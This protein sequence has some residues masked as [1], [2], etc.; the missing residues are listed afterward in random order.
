MDWTIQVTRIQ[1][2]IVSVQDFSGKYKADFN[3]SQVKHYI[4][5][6]QQEDDDE[7]VVEIFHNALNQF[8]SEAGQKKPKPYQVLLTEVL[9]PGDPREALFDE[10]KKKEIQ[11]LVEKGTWKVILKSEMSPN[12]NILGGRFVLAIKDAGTDKEKWKARFVVQGHRD[13][14]KTSLVHDSPTARQHSTRII[15]GLAAI[16]GFRLFST[17]VTQA[18][19]QSSTDLL[20]DVYMKP[21]KEFHLNENQIL[22]LLKPLYGLPDSGDYWGKTFTT[23]LRDELGMELATGDGAL[24]FKHLDDKLKGLCATY[25]D[26]T[27]QAG[28][29]DFQKLTEN[30]LRKFECG[31][32][33]WDNTEF[34]GVQIET[35]PEEFQIYQT[36]YIEN[37]KPLAKYAN[38][39]NCRSFRAQLSWVANTRPDIAC[40]VAKSAQVTEEQ[41]TADKKEYIR[42]LNAILKRLRKV[43]HLPLRYPRLDK[44]SLHL[45]VYT[46]ASYA[47]NTDKSSQ[48][49]YIIFL[50]DS[51]GQCQPMHWS[52]HKSKRVTR[53]VLGSETMALADGFDMAYMIKHDIQ[54][55]TKTKIPLYILTDS[56]SLFDVITKLSSTTE[57]RLLIDLTVVRKAYASHEIEKLGFVRTI[58]NPADALT[59]VMRSDALEQILR[60]A[61]LDLPVHQWVDR[62]KTSNGH[63]KA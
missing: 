59:K 22:K 53:S 33:E 56:L 17:D 15:V 29:R 30:T 48:L 16:F 52:S 41:F 49:G 55:M 61:R 45:Q 23:H 54:R 36:R 43:P 7:E 42:Y 62:S 6:I 13:K 2:K 51:T 46:D 31:K 9:K 38:F 58:Y 27:L 24:F 11:G 35:L 60:T 57:K 28:D 32:R 44:N 21:T 10:A 39:S 25:V 40:A 34:A 26:D 1:G 19:L 8:R 18:Y 3:I 50:R 5:N 14:Y 63:V 47:T 12:P 37:L 20:R 4:Q